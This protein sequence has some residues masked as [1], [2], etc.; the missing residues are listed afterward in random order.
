MDMDR[1]KMGGRRT[2]RKDATPRRTTIGSGAKDV[3]LS[4]KEA[5]RCAGKKRVGSENPVAGTWMGASNDGLES[6]I[7]L[8][9]PLEAGN[10]FRNHSRIPELKNDSRLKTF[11]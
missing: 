10:T 9:A 7:L 5:M 6:Q 1:E 2:R 4:A 3:I 11:T 8:L